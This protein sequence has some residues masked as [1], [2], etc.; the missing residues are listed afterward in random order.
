MEK[1]K[2]NEVSHGE[3]LVSQGE[4]IY[5]MLYKCF[6]IAGYKAKEVD[7]RFNSIVKGLSYGPPPHGGI[8]P[9]IDRI[10]MLLTDA[11]SIRDVIAFPFNQNGQDLLMKAYLRRQELFQK[12]K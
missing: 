2:S 3:S 10:L 8:A 6:D 5:S 4:S 11:P 9:G 1:E 7:I 12:L